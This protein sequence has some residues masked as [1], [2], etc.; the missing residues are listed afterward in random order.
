[1][2]VGKASASQLLRFAGAFMLNL[3][4]AVFGPAVI[5]SSV[6]RALPRASSF[7]GI[8]AKEWLLGLTGA[9]LLG[10][11]ISRRWPSSSAVWV[12]IVPVLFFALGAL[13]YSG[14]RTKSV[15]VDDGFWKHFFAPDC[16]EKSNCR[17]YFIFTIPA[18]RTAVY[19]LA[20][21]VSL[22]L[23]ARRAIA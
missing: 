6:W 23:R 8:E 19:S 14:R 1:M 18:V 4:V 9:A 7:T 22:R 16:F 5:E 11:F 15:L 13:A 10:F 2:N 20:A 21:W 12:W 17:D 3:A